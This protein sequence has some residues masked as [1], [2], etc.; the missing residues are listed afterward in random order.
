M[1]IACRCLP[2]RSLLPLA[3]VLCSAAAA[4]ASDPAPPPDSLR[5]T[6]AFRE[7]ILSVPPGDSRTNLYYALMERIESG[8]L[9]VE[10]GPALD[11]LVGFLVA[12]L[13]DP[14]EAAVVRYRIATFL[15]THPHPAARD[16]LRRA[17]LDT[18]DRLHDRARAAL[19]AL[20]D[21]A[22]LD[23]L[24]DEARRTRTHD[25]RETFRMIGEFGAARAIKPLRR[26]IAG[27]KL[28]QE[29]A[30]AMADFE[31]EHGRPPES[32]RLRQRAA[33]TARS[34]REHARRALRDV[35]FHVKTGMVMPFGLD[36]GAR[37]SL[38]REGFV[39]LPELKNELYEHLGSEYPYVTVDVV[40]HAF[41]LLARASFD[42][43]ERLVLAPKLTEFARGM[44]EACL[45]GKDRVPS[46]DDRGLVDLNAATFAVVLA[47]LEGGQI[48]EGA[49]DGS[50]V[51]A[52]AREELDAIRT[53]SAVLPSA[54]FEREED[55]TKY[56]PR[57]RH[58][59]SADLMRY[60]QAMLYLGRMGF[61]AES[62]S[63]TRRAL[64]LL[65]VLE[66]NPKLRQQW[67][68]IDTLLGMF[69]GPLDDAGVREYEALLREVAEDSSEGVAI[70]VLRDPSRFE[71]F[72]DAALALPVPRVMS[73]VP[74]ETDRAGSRGF[75]VLGQRY[76]RGADVFQQ[77][78]EGAQALPSGLHIASALLGSREAE[79][80]LVAEG[81]RATADVVTLP[82][83][84]E[85][86]LG[87]LPDGYLHCFEPLFEEASGRPEFMSGPVWERRLV[88]SSLG[89]W[90]EVVH[91]T[92]LYVKDANEYAGMSAM[93]DR[94]HG[95]VDPY[96]EFYIRL[97]GLTDR[98]V[99]A[100]ERCGLFDR[101]D[102]E[103]APLRERAA[104]LDRGLDQYEERTR[105]KEAGIRATR[106]MYAELR[107]ILPD[108]AAIAQKELRGEG[109]SLE[110]GV[111]LKGL[112]RKFKRLAFNWSSSDHHRESMA[113]I[114]DP[115][116]DY[117]SERCL[118]VGIGRPL[119]M[120]VAVPFGDRTY[121][122]RG[123]VYSYYEFSRPITERLD[124]ETW[125]RLCRE[126]EPDL[127][128]WFGRF[129]EIGLTR[130]ATSA[131]L[132]ALLDVEGPDGRNISGGSSPWRGQVF[133]DPTVAFEGVR[134]RD[135]DL[136]LLIRMA[137]RDSIDMRVRRFALR[138]LRDFGTRHEV[139]DA[140]RR[141][142]ELAG[143]LSLSPFPCNLFHVCAY[144]AVD[145][146]GYCGLAALP[147]LDRAE[148]MLEKTL[149][150]REAKPGSGPEV[151]ASQYRNALSEARARIARFP[152]GFDR[153][154]D[155]ERRF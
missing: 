86:P 54:L 107:D 44:T 40:F 76:S 71:A 30:D 109:Q 133:D 82:P 18:S 10:A 1:R 58:G 120:Y 140:Y 39:I 69:F 6:D 91:A 106:E 79:R 139:L 73:D 42:D 68:E 45:A 70:G 41:L 100:L 101:L 87:S 126:L 135:G 153:S 15:T 38:A 97:A 136:K 118:Q 17:A 110:D 43:L 89:G 19:V 103:V 47:A 51:V 50:A 84:A 46:P 93:L 29:M 114:T 81:R 117:Y 35:E 127:L 142:L 14:V 145:G 8:A 116:T 115:A 129:P 94:F 75:R 128:P 104:A 137:D 95:C 98:F 77:W 49:L 123:P 72:R 53:H 131:E 150:P 121:V 22:A 4:F 16:A 112:H 88:N 155:G 102:E 105:L 149:H 12:A 152:G 130:A 66:R 62:A 99:S 144:N 122:C 111:F 11:D 52:A 85:D 63:E 151:L 32:E 146:L 26:M 34:Y 108:L 13:D 147:E 36:D 119:V 9:P 24:L 132:E 33:T 141:Q 64:L 65:D 23:L 48:P 37:A 57:G 78:M 59:E 134:I 125:R 74:S 55:F 7:A 80:I 67:S 154:R 3:V 148:A 138:K 92:M 21:D 60:F 96:P 2:L 56:T 113:L 20:R 25:A 143:P 28:E 27:G 124:D 90:A 61:R 5:T 83:P 31:R